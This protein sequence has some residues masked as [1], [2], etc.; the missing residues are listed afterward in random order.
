MASRIGILA[1]NGAQLLDISGPLDVFAEANLQAGRQA[2]V[3]SIVAAVDGPVTCSSGA[4][5][6][7]DFIIGQA[8]MPRFDTLLVAGAPHLAQSAHSA[9]MLD[10][11][12][13]VST[14]ARRYGSVCT[15]AFLLAEAGLL[16]G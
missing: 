5:L 3:L 14:T 1:M 6:L 16:D 10:W 4:R 15:G 7:P 11:L 9:P 2:Y 8:G 13:A 12:C